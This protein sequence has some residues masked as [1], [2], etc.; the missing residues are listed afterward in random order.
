LNG[1]VTTRLKGTVHCLFYTPTPAG[2]DW[3]KPESFVG[4]QLVGKWLLEGET[5][6][7]DLLSQVGSGVSQATLTCSRRSDAAKSFDFTSIG[8]RLIATFQFQ[9]V[10]SLFSTVPGILDSR[11]QLPLQIG[12]SGLWQLQEPAG[13][14]IPACEPL[15]AGSICK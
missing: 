8:H 12:D 4:S 2:R 5:D 9:V 11:G 7:L 3:A 10:P 1:I 6:A 13:G 14:G 15:P